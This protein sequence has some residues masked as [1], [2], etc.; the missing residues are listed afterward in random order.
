MSKQT[1][2]KENVFIILYAKAWMQKPAEKYR[3]F[4]NKKWVIFFFKK[5]VQNGQ[6][7]KAKSLNTEKM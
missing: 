3:I 6:K 5:H 1:Q 2:I 7:P 4:W